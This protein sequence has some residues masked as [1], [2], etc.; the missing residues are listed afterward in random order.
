MVNSAKKIE[1]DYSIY[2][3]ASLFEKLDKG[4]SDMET[5]RLTSH[6]EAMKIITERFENYVLQHS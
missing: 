1:D 3:D 6:D 2:D 4:I 5:G